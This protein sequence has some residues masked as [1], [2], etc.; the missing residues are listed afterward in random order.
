MQHSN[1]PF[2]AHN[3]PLIGVDESRCCCVISL[4]IMHHFR[5]DP[6]VFRGIYKVDIASRDERFTLATV[7]SRVHCFA[8]RDICNESPQVEVLNLDFELS[9][10]QT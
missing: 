4:F 1:E 2:R 5:L 7:E 8:N 3:W 10:K 9:R 6:K